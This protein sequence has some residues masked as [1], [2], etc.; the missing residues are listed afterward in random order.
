MDRLMC[1]RPYPIA[2]DDEDDLA[3]EGMNVKRSDINTHPVHN[4]ERESEIRI[5]RG[6]S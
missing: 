5:S 2:N 4:G 6:T 1:V 3:L